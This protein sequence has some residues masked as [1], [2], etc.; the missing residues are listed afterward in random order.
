MDRLLQRQERPAH[1]RQRR[2]GARKTVLILRVSGP[3]SPSASTGSGPDPPGA[4]SPRASVIGTQRSLTGSVIPSPR[5]RPPRPRTSARE[6]TRTSG[7]AS[8][9][10]GAV[11]QARAW[12]T[13]K[14][15]ARKLGA[16]SPRPEVDM[17]LG[18]ARALSRG[19]PGGQRRREGPHRLGVE[20]RLGRRDRRPTAW[21]AEPLSAP[22]PV[23]G[24]K[25]IP[26]Q[27]QAQAGS[28]AALSPPSLGSA[29]VVVTSD[30]MKRRRRAWRTAS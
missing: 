23:R 26:H 21:F 8:Q 24:W 5:R 7:P 12:R 28:G 16:T 14:W 29:L 1:Q 18:A 20:P 30:S 3:G 25:A 22:P 9:P 6:A 17:S 11:T 19:R 4:P 10:V 13:R 2:P 27:R 15:F